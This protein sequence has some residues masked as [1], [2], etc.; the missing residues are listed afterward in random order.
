[1]NITFENKTVVI[2]GAAG[3]LGK[4]MAERFAADGARVAL[5][6]LRGA[7]DAAAEIGGAARGYSFDITDREMTASFMKQ[8][9]ADMNG[10]DVLVNNAGIN[11]GPEE[12]KTVDDFSDK[13]WD[14][15]LKVDLDGTY[16]CTKAALAYMKEGGS[17]VNISSI[18]GMVP[19]RN[20][21]AFTAAK[22][23]VIN[24]TKA[25]AMELAPKGIRANT[26]CPGTIGIA[27]TNKLWTANAAM[28]GL[29]SHIPMA[30]QGRPDEIANATAFLA[31]DL[32][33]YV[34]G[35]VLPVDGG[36]TCGGY[37]RNF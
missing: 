1:M 14:A 30:R 20:Q 3:G 6:D 23:G 35:A 16:N 27:V 13:W 32:A 19:L 31:S 8:I 7:E 2:T 37:A 10:I 21:C 22:A 18:V 5:C 33:S 12:R 15:I 9:A 26:I 4:A 34:T 28:E 25:I 29:L 11:V 17:I 24:F 36:W